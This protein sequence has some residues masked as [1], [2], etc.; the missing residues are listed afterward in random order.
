MKL[1][2]LEPEWLQYRSTPDGRRSMMRVE[3]IQ[4]A[5]GMKFLCPKCFV[6]N[7]GPVGT[8]MVVCWFEG[9]VPDY[10]VPGP[11]RWTPAGSGF[12]DLTF[13]PGVRRSQVSVLLTGGCGWHGF[14]ANGEAT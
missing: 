9:R 11:G 8:H 3:S 7:G 5:H 4:D 6:A 2:E 13:V 12:D 1:T 10:A 14:I